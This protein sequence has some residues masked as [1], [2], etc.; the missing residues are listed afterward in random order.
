[1]NLWIIL[2]GAV[3]LIVLAG[4]AGL[5]DGRARSDAWRSVAAARRA[6]WEERQRLAT[7]V[8]SLADDAGTCQCLVCR[9]VRGMA[10]LGD[11][12]PGPEQ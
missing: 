4:L 7:V 5:A 8:D 11:G 3:L 9:R 12:P 6:N 2:V 1:V 10:G